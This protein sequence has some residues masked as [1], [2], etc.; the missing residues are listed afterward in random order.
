MSL[1]SLRRG[2]FPAFEQNDE[3]GVRRRLT[4]EPTFEVRQVE[5]LHWLLGRLRAFSWHTGDKP[6]R[7]DGGE[8]WWGHFQALATTSGKLGETCEKLR[9]VPH[10]P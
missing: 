9:P 4:V 6:W 2:P 1:T 3:Q 5:R 8:K 7:T 10:F